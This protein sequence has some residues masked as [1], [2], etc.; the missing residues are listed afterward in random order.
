MHSVQEVLLI[1]M[2]AQILLIEILNLRVGVK[3]DGYTLELQIVD[4][5]IK[6]VSHVLIVMLTTAMFVLIQL[7]KILNFAP[8]KMDF[9]KKMALS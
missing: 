6:N 9:L 4:N 2:C 1:A 3:L 7:E 5:V 8:A